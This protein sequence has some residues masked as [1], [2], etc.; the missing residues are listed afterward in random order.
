M[1]YDAPTDEIEFSLKAVAGLGQVAGLPGLEAY[2]EDIVGPILEEAA[3]L[4]RDVLAPLNPVGDS[5]GARLEADGVI[6]PDGFRAAYD[7]FRSGG[8]MGLAAPEA[9]GG[10]GLPRALALGVMEMFHAANMAF[11]LCPMLSQGA[12]EALLAHGTDAQKQTYLPRLVSGD[13]TGT[14]NLT[15]PQAGSDVGA[16][17]T[18]AVPNPDGSFAITGQKI[19]ITW[20]DHDLTDNIIHLVLARLPGAPAGSRGISLFIVPKFIVNEDGSPGARNAV[21]CIGLEKKIGIH[22]SPTCVMEY[23]G[24]TGWLIGE[25]NKGLAC[26]FTMMN[27][28]RLNVGLEGVGVGEAAYQ[29]AFN[30]AQERKQ[31][32]VDGVAGAAPILHHADVRRTLITMRARVAAARAI[33]YACGV[34]ADLAHASNVPAIR[35]ASKARE[36]LLTPIAKAWSTD[37]GVDVASLG[38]QVHG[39]MGYMSETLAAQ[40]YRDA[41]IAPIYEGTNGIQAIDLV[42]RKLAGNGGTSMRAMLTEIDESVRLARSTNDPQFVQLAERLWAASKALAEATDWMLARMKDEEQDK[43]LAGATAYLALAGD[44]IGGHFLARAALASRTMDSDFRARQTALAGFFAETALAAAP[45]RVPG[46]IEGGDRFLANSR[47]LFG[48]G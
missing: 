21:R 45:G 17:S 15:E 27:S 30:Y 25:A 18:K 28:A 34:A 6:A 42:G 46:I 3:K 24:A 33:C 32:K 22:A 11:G 39:G 1:A 35:A 2:D 9:W 5:Q 48:I 44:V 26:M 8:W 16:L 23:A 29:A 7:A 20:G 10:Q 38:V 36:D 19:Y 40:L 31:G 13:W 4:A 14:M 47:A 43:A 41:R 12:I 37:M